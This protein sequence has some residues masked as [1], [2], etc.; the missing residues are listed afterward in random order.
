MDFL[1]MNFLT[2]ELDFSNYIRAEIVSIHTR[3]FWGKI[4]TIGVFTSI[5]FC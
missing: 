1:T 4:A 3:I 2:C 5:A